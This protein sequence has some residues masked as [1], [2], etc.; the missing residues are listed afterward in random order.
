M[1]KDDL[2]DPRDAFD[3]ID[4]DM[5]W[6]AMDEELEVE[7]AHTFIS[8]KYKLRFKVEVQTAKD[9][10]IYDELCDMQRMLDIL[11]SC[12]YADEAGKLV[13][14]SLMHQ[15]R[16]DWQYGDQSISEWNISYEDNPHTV[17]ISIYRYE[18]FKKRSDAWL[19]NHLIND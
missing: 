4:F 15:M 11:C 17:F 5:R 8:D 19:V 12:G 13:A 2:G 18:E 1:Y 6:E 16:V 3:P 7:V 10:H 14:E 9:G